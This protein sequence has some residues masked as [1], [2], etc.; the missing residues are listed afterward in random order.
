MKIRCYY[1][2]SEHQLDHK[3]ARQELCPS[4]RKPLHC[5][6]N[7]RFYDAAAYHQCR[8]PQAE[9]TPDKEEPNFCEYFDAVRTRQKASD[10]QADARKKLDDLFK[11]SS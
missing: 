5:C 2:R 11:G 10:R 3:V 8:E 9:F 7:C 1:C 6:R 4:C